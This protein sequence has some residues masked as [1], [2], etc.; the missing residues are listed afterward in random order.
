MKIWESEHR[1]DV[2]DDY[3]REF[4][5]AIVGVYTLCD[6]S[7]VRRAWD[8]SD[9]KIEKLENEII[10]SDEYNYCLIDDGKPVKF[11]YNQY[12][13]NRIYGRQK[14]F[15][16]D[17]LS[18]VLSGYIEVAD[19]KFGDALFGKLGTNNHYTPSSF[20]SLVAD[21]FHKLYSVKLHI[22]V[23]RH[24]RIS[25]FLKQPNLTYED[26]EIFAEKCAH[27]M[28]TS[29]LYLRVD[30]Q[31]ADGYSKK[32]ELNGDDLMERDDEDSTEI[33]TE[34]KVTE[35]LSIEQPPTPVPRQVSTTSKPPAI[36]KPSVSPPLSPPLSLDLNNT[37]QWTH[38]TRKKRTKTYNTDTSDPYKKV[39]QNTKKR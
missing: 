30:E 14:Y 35:K 1:F 5:K 25:T 15:I 16:P 21:V 39:Y 34:P 24:S 28:L 13:T 19:L 9:M 18:K 26:K 23:I 29:S 4:Y 7:Y 12:K 11:V 33:I 38:V 22:N 37:N 27:S 36:S 3:N 20:A 10:L 32:I 6:D 31:D 2:V 17:K 8:Y